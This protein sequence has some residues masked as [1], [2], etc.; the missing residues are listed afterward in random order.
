L[1]VSRD[2]DGHG[3]HVAAIAAGSKEPYVGIAPEATL[4]MVK[5]DFQDAH[6]ADGIRYIFRL[7]REMNLPAVVNLS[8]GGHADAHDGSDS[9]SKIIDAETGPGRLV[10]CAAGNEGNSNIHAQVVLSPGQ[11]AYIPFSV[12]A[13]ATSAAWLNGWY[14]G[15]APFEICVRTPGGFITPWQKVISLGYPVKTYNLADAIVDISTPP[16]DPMNKDHNFFVQIRHPY[17]YALKGGTWQLR[18]RNASL[19][20]ARLDAWTVDETETVAFSGTGTQDSMK[21]GSPGAASSAITVASYTTRNQWTD[22]DNVTRQMGL[23]LNNASDFSSEGPLRNGNTKPDVAAPGA[24]IIS[25]LSADSSNP[26]VYLVDK[27]YMV[28]MG[29]SM[30]SPFIAGI[31]ALMLQRNPQLDPAKAKAMLKEN[32][33]I[34]GYPSGTFN[35]KYG[36]GLVNAM[37]L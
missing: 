35:P 31:L 21:I 28:M 37:N 11:S 15:N 14:P 23:E 9:L 33:I 25:A 29:T 16:P 8:L 4:V 19:A 36:F 26:R 27:E 1:Q 5:T 24:M 3:T 6:I 32:S 10:C 18:V 7:A 2:L 12:P 22:I 30:A 17:G 34:P 20:T 13:N